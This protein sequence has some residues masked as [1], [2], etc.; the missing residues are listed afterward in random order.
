MRKIL[1]SVCFV[2][3]PFWLSAA[4]TEAQ[5]GQP[6]SADS[7]TVREAKDQNAE[8]QSLV[9]ELNTLRD[10]LA[11]KQAELDKLRHKWTVNKGR[12]PTAAEIKKFE[13]KRAKGPVTVE[14]NPFINK[15]PLSSPSR[16]RA[17]YF[18]KLAEINDDEVRVKMLEKELDALKQ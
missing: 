5:S 1:F 3:F 9:Q 7:S 12:M 10:G 18:K 13:E 8:Y 6:G 15:N 14:D 11:V 17:A 16:F 4:L 2:A